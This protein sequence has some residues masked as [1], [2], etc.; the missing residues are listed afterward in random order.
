M[1]NQIF[2]WLNKHTTEME[3]LQFFVPRST[4]QLGGRK[5]AVI[6]ERLGNISPFNFSINVSLDRLEVLSFLH[7]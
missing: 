1:E 4:A 3:I 2:T 7:L 6:V 5:I